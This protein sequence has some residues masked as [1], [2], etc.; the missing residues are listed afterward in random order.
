MRK[1]AHIINPVVVDESSDLYIAQPITFETMKIAR[2][3][4]RDQV[5][6]TLFSAQYSM[7]R[8]LAPE[9]FQL[10]PDLTHSVLDF[11]TFHQQRKLPL[12]KD[13]LDRLYEATDADY[14]IYT[15][16]DIAVMPYFYVAVDKII[17]NG[18][19]AFV[20]NRRTISE[21]Y[22][23]TDQLYLMFSQVG[24]KHPGYDCFV[25]H[26]ALYPEF[27]LGTVCIGANW[28][29][30]VLLTNLI[31]H[32]KK[33][34]VFEDL[35]VSFH[36]GDE[37][38]WTKP[39]HQ[40]YAKHNEK[41]LHKI[42]LKNKASGLFADKPLVEGFLRHIENSSS[43]R[44]SIGRRRMSPVKTSP[45]L[46]TE[47][48]QQIVLDEIILP[49]DPIFVVGFP[50]SGTTLL[51][52]LLATQE[53]IYSLPETHFFCDISNLI[54]TDENGRI[55]GLCLTKVF[56]RI[57]QKMGLEFPRPVAD[58][59]ILLAEKKELSSKQLFEMIVFHFLY[60][61]ID[62]YYST[63]FRWIEKTPY[64]FAHL[65]TILKF[66][67]SAKF[68]AIIRNPV[69][70]INST[71]KLV[72]LPKVSVPVR[73]Y[74]WNY[75]I[76]L[77]ENFRER[78]PRRIYLL[79]YEDLVQNLER[80]ISTLCD[81]LDI[82]MNIELLNRYKDV[83]SRFILP[84]EMWKNDVRSKEISNTNK[85]HRVPL[86]DVL[87]IQHFTQENMQKYGYGISF[88]SI[89]RAFDFFASSSVR[90]RNLYRRVSEATKLII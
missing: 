37:R 75:M 63:K 68:A 10:T 23:H 82:E 38:R 72:N 8:P 80:E 39:A 74:R 53:G 90:A 76:R 52:A 6:V 56:E 46:V 50:R 34:K 87:I 83:S 4:A 77:I 48:N 16:V 41:E 89:Q 1:I 73:A 64:H 79:R 14:L 19:D 40:D 54:E 70:T 15:N 25:F 11:G 66:Y 24:E 21:Q 47:F 9:G 55:E 44:F 13:I 58:R 57:K 85:S 61:Q 62:D 86:L 26:R 36:I 3:F 30:R 20:I 27:E 12:I 28:I 78:H 42:L 18:Y 59:I 35:H 7:D 22:S 43:K 49:Q 29:G 65:D 69:P 31:C 84:W 17:E 88:P 71:K 81:Y 51:Q 67:P 33:F 32:S 5:E 60:E 2:E 45:Q